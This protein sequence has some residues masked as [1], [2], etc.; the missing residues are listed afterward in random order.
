MKVNHMQHDRNGDFIIARLEDGEDLIGSMKA[1]AGMYRIE[2]GIIL[3]GIG[4][5]RDFEISLYEKG[6]YRKKKVKGP[7]ELLTTQGSIAHVT[8]PETG[9][10]GELLPHLHCTLGQKDQTVIGGHL[11]S[12]TVA[13]L[14]EIT[15]L[16]LDRVRL[17]RRL[18]EGTEL[19]ELNV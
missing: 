8:D 5:L 18:N 13:V 10:K 19:Y 3:A 7:C 15:I 16:G 2:S 1:L 14:N 6:K 9:E 12:G 11:N 17:R 4:M